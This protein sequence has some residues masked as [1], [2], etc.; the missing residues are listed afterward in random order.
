M[1]ATPVLVAVQRHSEPTSH[2]SSLEHEQAPDTTSQVSPIERPQVEKTYV[3][4][5]STLT[6]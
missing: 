1:V 6:L 4:P 3:R 2:A 5:A